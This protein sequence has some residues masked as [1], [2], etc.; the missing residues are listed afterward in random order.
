MLLELPAPPEL[1]NT[2]NRRPESPASSDISGCSCPTPHC[3]P[4]RSESA[5]AFS[6]GSARSNRS[7]TPQRGVCNPSHFG[8][9]KGWA[10]SSRSK[11]SRTPQ[12]GVP[13]PAQSGS[14]KGRASSSRSSRS[15]TP[16]RGV[17]NPAQSGSRKGRAS[18][19]RFSRSRTP[20]R[21]VPNPSQSGSRK[22]CASSSRSRRSRTPQRGVR[23]P[24]LSERGLFPM[25]QAKYQKSVLGKLVE[26]LDEIKRVGRHYE[27]LN[28]AV[29]VARLE[30]LEDFA[31]EEARLKDRNLW[32]QRVSQLSKVG[33]R[34]HKDCV[35]KVMERYKQLSHG[36]NIECF[37]PTM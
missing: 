21:G 34:N 26:L 30:T 33:A 4:T 5:E 24:S 28:S 9:R 17:P 22:G 31:E 35:H 14:R 29:H 6:P 2:I 23:M 15:C 8:S 10:S 20:Q 25:S 36:Q 7:H 1:A 13:N 19:S 12:R 27:P 32:E 18:S 3:S 16:Q 11:R 37:S